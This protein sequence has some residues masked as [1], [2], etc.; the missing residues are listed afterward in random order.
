MPHYHFQM[1]VDGNVTINFNA[2]HIPFTDY[3]EFCFA[4]E[5]GKFERLR[6][7]RR[8]DAGMQEVMQLLEKSEEFREGLAYA[9][10]P[11]TATFSTDIFIQAEPGETISGDQIADM[12][13]E[14]KKTGKSLAVLAKDLDNA[15][16]QTWISP[17]PG[18]PEMARRSGGRRKKSQNPES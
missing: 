11:E 12:I 8:A 18:V 17:G 7:I 14:R 15:N 5:A 16:V 1:S 4:L 10:N 3:D 13:Q 6:P 9:E 2:F